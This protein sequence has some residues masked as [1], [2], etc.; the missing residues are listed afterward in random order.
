[1]K[2]KKYNYS[3]VE[4]ENKSVYYVKEDSTDQIIESFSDWS[5]ARKCMKHLNSGGGFDGFTPTFFLK[6]TEKTAK[7]V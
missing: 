2:S 3:I 7:F 5:D 1:M 4:G 6:N